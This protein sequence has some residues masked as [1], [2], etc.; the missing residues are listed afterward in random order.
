MSQFNAWHPPPILFAHISSSVAPCRLQPDTRTAEYGF[1]PMHVY[2]LKKIYTRVRVSYALTIHNPVLSDQLSDLHALYFPHGRVPAF[3]TPPPYTT[4]T[5]FFAYIV[6]WVDRPLALSSLGGLAQSVSVCARLLGGSCAL[7]ES[8]VLGEREGDT[9]HPLLRGHVAQSCTCPVERS[10]VSPLSTVHSL[11][12][13][14][15]LLS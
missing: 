12:S 14:P 2:G 10:V 15:Y 4:Y 5:A 1:S 6:H 9:Q 13:S 11:D 7:R 3:K 8:D